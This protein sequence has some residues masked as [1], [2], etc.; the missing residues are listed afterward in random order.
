M[1]IDNCQFATVF[2]LIIFNKDILYVI[3]IIYIFYFIY[4]IYSQDCT[5]EKCYSF[6]LILLLFIN[7]T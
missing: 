7:G 2:A 6:V 5:N 4:F 1:H 3:N